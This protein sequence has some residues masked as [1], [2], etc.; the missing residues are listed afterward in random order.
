MKVL[1]I[2]GGAGAGKSTALAYLRERYGARTLSLDQVAHRLMEPGGSCYAPILEA[3]GQVCAPDGRIDRAKLYEAS[4][5]QDQTR[6]RLNAI[7]HPRVK[8]AVR[9]WVARAQQMRAGG[10]P[11][12]ALEAALLLEDNYREICQEIWYVR[13]GEAVRADRMRE[14]RG[15]SAERARQLFRAQMTDQAFQS[16]CDFVVENETGD[17]QDLYRQLDRGVREHGF[18]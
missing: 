9:A 12:L 13:A 2:T 10:A 7:V 17:V 4:F 5:R 3:F 14:T 1:G 11:F 18:V 15:Y 16:A 6:E 8:D